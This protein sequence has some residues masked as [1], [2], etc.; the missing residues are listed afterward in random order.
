M[1]SF[2]LYIRLLKFSAILTPT[3]FSLTRKPPLYIGIIHC[4]WVLVYQQNPIQYAK[5]RPVYGKRTGEKVAMKRTDY[6]ST[7]SVDWNVKQE[8]CI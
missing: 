2:K 1:S 3:H 4:Y 6:E 8:R 5:D 7:S